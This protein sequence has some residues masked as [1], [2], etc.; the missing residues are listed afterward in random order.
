M[1][2]AWPRSD[3]EIST[4]PTAARAGSP[5]VI[6]R[7]SCAIIWARISS[8]LP[9]ASETGSMG[10]AAGGGA[11]GA[12]AGA[13]DLPGRRTE[14]WHFGHLTLKGRSGTRAS[15]ITMRCAQLGQ[16]VCNSLPLDQ[17]VHLAGSR[18]WRGPGGLAG[19]GTALDPDGRVVA[20]LAGPCTL[21]LQAELQVGAV[22]GV[23]QRRLRVDHL[24]SDQL[25]Q[26][27]VE[28]LH[29]VQGA[30]G[31]GVG[32]AL[33]LALALLHVFLGAG[34]GAQDLAHGEAPAALL[35]DEP[36]ADHPAEGL[37]EARAHLPL[38]VLGED[39]HD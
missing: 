36:L 32:E 8:E 27:A 29:P 12:A 19:W 21:R 35:G 14:V 5:S 15:S 38:L 33:A 20:V 1:D 18:P 11:G 39:A 13:A 6:S 25:L 23:G 16:L 9:P 30:V 34:V 7:R 28:G 17:V 3:S 24:G 22:G 10:A 4:R 31:H 2:P 26:L 37:R